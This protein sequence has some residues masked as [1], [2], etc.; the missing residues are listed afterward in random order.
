MLGPKRNKLT[1]R[2]D[3][4][5]NVNF[6]SNINSVKVKPVKEVFNDKKRLIKLNNKKT[7]FTNFED[8][9]SDW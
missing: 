7:K 5:S 1:I 3:T 6:V 9:D 2:D 8:E 4:R